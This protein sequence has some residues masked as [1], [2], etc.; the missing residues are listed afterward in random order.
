MVLW[1]SGRVVNTAKA[2]FSVDNYM[3]FLSIQ[4]DSALRNIVPAVSL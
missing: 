3:D 1:L 4:A 2:V